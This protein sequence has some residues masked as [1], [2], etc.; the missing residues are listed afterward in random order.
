MLEIIDCEQNSPEWMAARCGII[1]ASSFHKVLAKGQGI[2][3]KGYMLSLAAERI[4][5]EAGDSFSNQYTERG[6]EFEDVARELYIAHTGA[7]VADCGFMVD[8]YGYSPDGLVGNNGLIEIKTRSGHLQVELLLADKVPSEHIAQIQGALMISGRVWCDFISFCP[9]LPIFI[10]R[11][12][13]D[14]AYIDNLKTELALFEKELDE[15]VNKI[16]A[17]F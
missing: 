2:T 11:V 9:G 1:T 7:E 3:R 17:K 5:G 6:H 10:K 8:T 13:K 12:M 16:L 14:D 4:R 15:M